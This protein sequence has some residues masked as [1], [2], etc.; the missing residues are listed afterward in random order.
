[1]NTDNYVRV[2][3]WMP[4]DLFNSLNIA[5]IQASEPLP[6]AMRARLA[7]SLTVSQAAARSGCAGRREGASASSPTLGH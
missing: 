5:A 3:L 2:V 7:S 6:D 4:R 1:M